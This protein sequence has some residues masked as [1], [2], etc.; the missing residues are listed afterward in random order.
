TIAIMKDFGVE[1]ERNEYS[2]FTIH[3]SSYL[4]ITSY[5]IESDASAASYFFAAPAICG[6]T[7][8]VENI[9]RKSVQ[10]DVGF[11]GC[12]SNK[13]GVPSKKLTTVSLVTVHHPSSA[14]T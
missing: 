1:I 14:L 12:A 11:S 9:S 7:V 2:R 5:P 10:G 6:G 8:K 13:W 3:P 4:P